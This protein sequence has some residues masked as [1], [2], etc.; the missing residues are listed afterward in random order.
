MVVRA[1]KVDWLSVGSTLIVGV[2]F[3]A[4]IFF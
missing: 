1:T 4:A 3:V 2:F